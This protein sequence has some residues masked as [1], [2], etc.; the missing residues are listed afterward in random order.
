MRRFLGTSCVKHRELSTTQPDSRKQTTASA[1][2]ISVTIS[3]ECA[4]SLNERS[5]CFLSAPHH[6]DELMLQAAAAAQQRGSTSCGRRRESSSVQL[7]LGKQPAAA[8]PEKAQKTRLN[9]M[10]SCKSIALPRAMR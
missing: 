2:H 4:L 5:D 9:T 8:R 6:P 3:G 10:L 1:H 7:H